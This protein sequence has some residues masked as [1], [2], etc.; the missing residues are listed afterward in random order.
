[1]AQV[2]TDENQRQKIRRRKKGVCLLRD[3]TSESKAGTN[4][5]HARLTEKTES[6]GGVSET[7]AKSCLASLAISG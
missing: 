6:K 5:V 4:A 3:Y 2:L 1:L 7:D